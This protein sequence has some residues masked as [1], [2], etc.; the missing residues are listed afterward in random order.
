VPVARDA[1]VIEAGLDFNLSPTAMLG[2]SYGGQFGSG[3]TDQSVK[4]TFNWKF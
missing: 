2:L 4:G 1:A 3:L